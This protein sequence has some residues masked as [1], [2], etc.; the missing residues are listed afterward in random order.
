MEIPMNYEP[1]YLLFLETGLDIISTFTLRLYLQYMVKD[2]S[3]MVLARILAREVVGAGICWAVSWRT[4]AGAPA[5]TEVLLVNASL[6]VSGR[7][8]EFP[9][10]RKRIPSTSCAVAPSWRSFIRRSCTGMTQLVI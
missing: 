10:E 7:Q 5:A 4:L 3:D 1:D 9:F 8:M 2:M 6:Y